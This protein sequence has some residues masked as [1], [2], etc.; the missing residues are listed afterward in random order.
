M[1]LQADAY[2]PDSLIARSL[3]FDEKIVLPKVSC[4]NFVCYQ[5]KFV[6]MLIN[7]LYIIFSEILQINNFRRQ[8]LASFCASLCLLPVNQ[9]TQHY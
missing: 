6:L 2:P 9:V 1:K 3:V 4:L 5:F 8:H 7:F